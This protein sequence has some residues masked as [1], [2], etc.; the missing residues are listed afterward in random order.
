MT[1]N[2]P[3]GETVMSIFVTKSSKRKDQ[4]KEGKKCSG[5]TERFYKCEIYINHMLW[6]LQSP[7]PNPVQPH[8]IFWGNVLAHCSAEYL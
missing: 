2:G 5:L 8:E 3:W 7:D 4:Q 1:L 6:P